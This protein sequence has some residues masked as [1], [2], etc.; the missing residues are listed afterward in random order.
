MRLATHYNAHYEPEFA[1]TY[2][3]NLS[4]RYAYKD[5]VAIAQQQIRQE[6][7]LEE[8]QAATELFFFDTELIITKI[9]FEHV[10]GVCP[11]FV[12]EQLASSPMD[13]Y[14]LC[15]PD[16]P[17]ESDPVRENEHLRQFLFER[18]ECEVKATGKPYA[19]VQGIDNERTSCAIQ[20][21]EHY[22]SK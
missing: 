7:Q 17:W 15:A 20:A 19:I 22:Y 12:K 4:M 11:V 16:L 5:V 18:Y 10:Y 3:E 14:L 21:I 1:R 6:K 13:L 2:I 9:W 8:Q